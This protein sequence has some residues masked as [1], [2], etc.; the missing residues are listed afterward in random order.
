MSA[1]R[2]STSSS[3][4]RRRCVACGGALRPTHRFCPN[5][6]TL[7]GAT[8]QTP[9]PPS[10]VGG[11]A[12]LQVSSESSVDLSE[13]RRLVT[14]LFA[15][16]EGSTSL[17]ERLDAEDLRRILTSFFGAL[18]REI[19]RY[20]GTVDKY[21]GDAV[22][23]VFGAPVAH[24]D[25]AERAISAAIAMQAAIGQLNEDLEHRYGQRLGLRMGINTGEVVAGLLSGEVQAYT[26]VGDTV[27]TAQR[28]ESA[29]TDGSILVGQ[30]TRDLT[31]RAFDFETLVPL[32]MKGKAEPQPAFR[33]LGPRYESVD[34]SAVPL[35]GR[36]QELAMLRDAFQASSLGR[37]R[38]VHLEGDAGIG[39][40]RLVRELRG[41][42]GADVVQ[43]V[44]RCVSFEVDRPFA[45]LARLIRDVVRVPTGND[46]STAR[47]GIERVLAGIAPTVDPLDTALL[48]NVLGY[49]EKLSYDPQSRQRVLLRLLRRLLAA[50]AQQAPVLIVAEDLHWADPASCALLHDLARDIPA[51][52]CLLMSTARPGTVPPWPA[53]IVALEALP[54]S[55]ARALIESAFAAPVEDGLAETILTRTGGNPF[56][57]EEVVRGLR[58]ADVVVERDGRMAARPESMPRVPTTVQEVLEARLDR[59]ASAHKRAL[60]VAAVCGRVFRQR[61]IEHLVPDLKRDDS[62]GLLERES[63]IL[64]HAVE[65]EPTFAFRHALIQEVAYNGQLQAQLRATHAAIGAALELLYPDRLDEL[66]GEL[67]FHFGLSPNDGKAV[68]WLVRAGDRARALFANTEA[69]GYYSAALERT[70]QDD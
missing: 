1:Q 63:F 26:V 6:G 41:G 69:L 22:M 46:E 36:A 18:S 34:P 42:T 16:I 59:L 9:T 14:V 67:A 64:S 58:E 44:G 47:A 5:C 43:V 54:Q 20:G 49:G 70:G 65:P 31:R 15:D 10:Q 61:L 21:A 3:G 57:I 33:V 66:V 52:R 7:V 50:Y 19:Q 39:K 13:N 12:A 24:E 23:A 30:T 68:H 4:T 60:Q 28:F 37:G 55:S 27:N 11:G 17:G 25:D 56:F 45:L 48:L 8:S 38:M 53:Q 51:R 35:V 29:A 32:V 2:R 62:L 40:S